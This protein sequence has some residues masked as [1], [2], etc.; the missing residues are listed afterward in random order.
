MTNTSSNYQNVC[1]KSR[2][3]DKAL[4]AST[5]LGSIPRTAHKIKIK[6]AEGSC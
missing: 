1:F 5:K 3:S 2:F 4:L 6:K